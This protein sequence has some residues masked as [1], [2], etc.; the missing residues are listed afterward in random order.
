MDKTLISISGGGIGGLTAGIA[1]QKAGFQ[2]QIFEAAPA[3]KPLGAGITLSF[4]AL[5]V[6]QKLGILDQIISHGHPLESFT[7]RTKQGKALANS[8]FDKVDAGDI[9]IK[10]L[11]IHRGDLQKC[12]LQ[13]LDTDIIQ[14]NKKGVAFREMDNHI[15]LE[16]K[17]GT[18]TQTDFLVGADGIHSHIRRQLFPTIEKRYAG[19]TCWRGLCDG[20]NI[21]WDWR[22]AVES[23]GT[24]ERFGIVPL[25]DKQIYWYFVKNA[26]QNDLYMSALD[27]KQL[28]DLLS[29]WHDPIPSIVEQTA[30]IDIIWNDILDIPPM[31]KW[32]KGNI[33][34]LGDAAHATTPNMG[35][36]ACQA[37]E[38][39]LVLAN[40]FKKYGPTETAL[41][42]YES[43]RLKRTAKV[44][45]TSWRIGQFAHIEMG[46]FRLIRNTMM[47]LSNANPAKW[48]FEVDFNVD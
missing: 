4:N 29:D 34:L 22:K 16:F 40:A 26:P 7:L 13:N 47:R 17:D 10:T 33:S 12:L 30:D 18:S 41:R 6:F 5:Q 14:N 15:L 35:Q 38:D 2:C 32:G 25:K 36:G 28:L 37:I 46:L 1:L 27:Q 3:Y 48:L 31:K 43:K 45:K 42:K 8:H 11:T 20:K 19:Y 9:G 23:W 44:T 24:G 39:A 21:N